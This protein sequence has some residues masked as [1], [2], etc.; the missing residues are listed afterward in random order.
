MAWYILLVHQGFEQLIKEQLS[1]KQKELSFSEISIS[2]ELSGY[3]FIRSIEIDQQSAKSFLATE[4]TLKFLGPNKHPQKFTT[5]QIKKLNVADVE[6]KAQRQTE[7]K[8]GDHVI[9]KHGDL[10][11]IDGV[12]IELR[13]RIV[14]IRPSYFSKIVKARVQDIGFL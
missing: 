6:L 7:F 8:I 13:K 1:S 2:N 4:G 12:I 3:V 11:D 10:A 14:K 5:A 9:I